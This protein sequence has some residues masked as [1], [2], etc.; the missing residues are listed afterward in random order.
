LV[1]LPPEDARQ[2][3][4]ALHTFAPWSAIVGRVIEQQ[5]VSIIFE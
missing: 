3:L 4:E 1:A 2:L 5:D